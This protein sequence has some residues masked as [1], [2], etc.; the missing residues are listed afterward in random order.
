MTPA[1]KAARHLPIIAL[2]AAAGLA[3][4]PH[5]ACAQPDLP[6]LFADGMVIQSERAVPI[7]GR[8][9]PNIRVTVEGSW[10]E[11]T[12]TNANDEGEWLARLPSPAAGGPFTITI[13]DTTGARTISD[14]LSGEVWIASGQSNM[15]MP[16][17][18]VSPQFKG[19]VGWRDAV[20]TSEDPMLRLI[21]VPD[22]ASATHHADTGGTWKHASP[23]T[24]GDFS[25][26][27]YFF[28]RAIRER[29][30]V[31]V[32][33]ITSDWGGTRAEAWTPIDHLGDFPR[34]ADEVEMMR[35]LASDPSGANADDQSHA[36]EWWAQVDAIDPGLENAW[37][38][39]AEGDA[40]WTNA[41]QPGIWESNGMP[42]FDGLVWIRRT[43][44]IPKKWVGQP[45]RLDL[46]MIDDQDAAYANGVMVGTTR[47]DGKW[48]TPRIYTIP[49]SVNTSATL[50]LAIR[51]VDVSG[52]GG[53]YG[54]PANMRLSLKDEDSESIPL[55]GEWERKP[56]LRANQFPKALRLTRHSPGALYNGMITPLIP[57]ANRGFLWY[58]GESNR[59]EADEYADLFPTM[60]RAWRDA[61][62]SPDAPFLFVQI[63]PFEYARENADETA[64]LRE[65]QRKSLRI[66]NTA[67]VVT[68]DIGEPR[69]I[70]P[71]EKRIVGER[72]ADAAGALA[73]GTLDDSAFCPV[74]SGA[75]RT[76]N[77]V[78]VSF[79][80]TGGS[81]VSKA[82]PAQG[83]ELRMPNGEWTPA[84]TESTRL[85]DDAIE[86]T[87]ADA[88]KATAVR[89]LWSPYHIGALFDARSQPVSPFMIELTD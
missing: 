24:T 5:S 56:A 82:D 37:F 18:Y 33:I 40:G 7:W 22:R 9:R 44:E 1:S 63:A 51:V 29:L 60:I 81:L 15:Q 76:T 10:G 46:G 41:I 65:S 6:D 8:A 2:F 58:Q 48:T 26:V 67:M 61:F 72:L 86:F 4:L 14:V 28:A 53:L 11:T 17:R 73:Y 25:A 16:V 3:G 59:F 45:L 85:V 21:D 35:N 80:F 38:A 70:H 62:Q 75:R 47:G 42:G 31:P 32:G 43:V 79:D 55:A 39:K 34:L 84:P 77:G 20:A 23:E 19:A 71:R 27:A 13:R 64:R 89:Y 50:S 74:P 54:E 66:P 87:G 57:Y 52:S 83:F 30:G 88:A 36:D 12:S 78:R 49:A 69:D 68:A